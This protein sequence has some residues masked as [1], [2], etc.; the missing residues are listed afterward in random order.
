MAEGALVPTPGAL[1]RRWF[2]ATGAR[3]GLSGAERLIATLMQLDA[4]VGGTV[5]VSA[6][7]I[8]PPATFGPAV[9][10]DCPRY[11]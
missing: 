6:T 11:T 5:T 3:P 10:T 2:E 4:A 1:V 7:D 8:F 9:N